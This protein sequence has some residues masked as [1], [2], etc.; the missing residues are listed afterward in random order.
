MDV[1]LTD[2]SPLPPNRQEATLVQR[3]ADFRA[4]A[5]IEQLRAFS[6]NTL[7]AEGGESPNTRIAASVGEHTRPLRA[8]VDRD[9]GGS[10][11]RIDAVVIRPP[12]TIELCARAAVQT[13]AAAGDFCDKAD[14]KRFALQAKLTPA[15]GVAAPTID[16]PALRMA[17]G[18]GARIING[19]ARVE[20]LAREIRVSA[21]SEGG[22]AILVEG[23]DGS[24]EADIAS[25][26]A[27]DL[28]TFDGPGNRFPFTAPLGTP[29]PADDV[30]ANKGNFV[31]VG[32]DGDRARFRGSIP[33][34]RRVEI[35]PRA[36]PEGDP[37]YPDPAAFDAAQAPRYICARLN[38]AAGEPLGLAVRRVGD[39]DVLRLEDGLITAMPGGEKPLEATIA[40]TPSEQETPPESTLMAAPVCGP[41]AGPPCRPPLLSLHAP[42]AEGSDTPLLRGSLLA[43]SA[44]LLAKLAGE[45]PRDE[46]ST[47]LNYDESPRSYP[48]NG[49]RV[50]LGTKFGDVAVRAGIR[51]ALHEY[52]DVDPPTIFTCA[53][54]VKNADGRCLADNVADP[55][56]DR[57]ADEGH[58]DPAR[59]IRRAAGWHRRR[60]ARPHRRLR[61]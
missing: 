54:L 28:N 20:D 7:T 56:R 40:T 12:D 42:R 10:A 38:A 31:T 55:T 37:R 44:S 18:A 11:Q 6:F 4:S 60:L 22:A 1:D 15:A 26:A 58:R 19:S 30:A 52:L 23:G 5:D 2:G 17:S 16:L 3:G 9:D 14:A 8:F 53:R 27:F 61:A 47:R 24:G 49:A 41:D 35:E 46:V 21:A 13:A 57:P 36:C 32:I 33:A 34:I 45:D 50:K 59:R 25:R 29:D 43:G 48:E 51:L 39:D